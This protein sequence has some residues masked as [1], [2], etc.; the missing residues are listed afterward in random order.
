MRRS[1]RA[2]LASLRRELSATL[3]A[4]ERIESAGGTVPTWRLLQEQR[5]RQLLARAEIEFASHADTVRQ[6]VIAAQQ[7]AIRRAQ[8]SSIRLIEEGF[9]PPPPGAAL[10]I[11]ALNQAAI[12]ELTAAL[13]PDAPVR[14]LLQEFAGDAV[15]A[16][17]DEIVGGVAAGNSP[18]QITR[19]IVNRLGN[20]HRV[21][22]ERI[23]RT[24]A[25]R[26]FREATR[27]TM[28]AN[29]HLVDKW[30]WYS[31][32]GTRT[33]AVCWSLHGREFDVDTK[34]STHPNC[35]CVLLPKTKSWKDL[36]YDVPDTRQRIETGP[37]LFARLPAP[38][39]RAVLGPNAFEL[40]RAGDVALNDFVGV[41]RST[42]W[43]TGRRRV[44]LATAM[45]NAKPKPKLA[46]KPKPEP[47]SIP[48][49]MSVA[50]IAKHLA[51][52]FGVT[53]EFAGWR[54]IAEP[55]LAALTRM[56]AAGKEW[57]G[58]KLRVRSFKDDAN[59]NSADLAHFNPNDETLHVNI[60][61]QYWGSPETRKRLYDNDWLSTVDDE[62]TILHEIGHSLHWE[63]IK[64]NSNLRQNWTR[65]L[66]PTE[67]PIALKVSRYAATQRAEFVAEVFSGRLKG[68]KYPKDVMEMYISFGG[69][70]V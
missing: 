13:Q 37:D 29:K 63:R 42:V 55:T 24:E 44:S 22:A 12:M 47:A 21:R 59:E 33:C 10:P 32:L 67:Q 53:A 70:L 46:P 31:G 17:Q 3:D 26:A 11:H 36:G 23:V 64:L 60:K 15:E 69:P 58:G 52:E 2:A 51:D 16:I 19:Q 49:Q 4:I 7:E 54:E 38:D 39:Q 65:E 57:S 6:E 41:T 43:G 8:E 45:K 61:S 34:M 9:G 68:N 14:K 50:E 18:Q 20:E 62:G 27:A 66:T 28:V 35:R 56:R 30:V 40:Y 25:M 48:A 1:Y 5:L